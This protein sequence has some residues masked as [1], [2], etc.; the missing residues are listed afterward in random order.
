MSRWDVE[1][2]ENWRKYTNGDLLPSFDIP[3]HLSI[4]IIP[5]FGGAL[6]RFRLIDK[7]DPTLEV[8][9]YF[10]ATNSLGYFG[11]DFKNPTP[12]WEIYPVYY[13]NPPEEDKK[14]IRRFAINDSKSLINVAVA[15]IEFQRSF[16]GVL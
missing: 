14:D 11:S 10:D 5:P 2:Q 13:T 4:K 15:S 12:Y 16:K 9:V 6:C 8:S 1:A 3:S 7:K